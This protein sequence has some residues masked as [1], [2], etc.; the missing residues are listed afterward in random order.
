VCRRLCA[1]GRH[2]LWL[3]PGLPSR[4]RRLPRGRA[5]TRG[6]HPQR[7]CFDRTPSCGTLT[8]MRANGSRNPT[9]LWHPHEK[10]PALLVWRCIRATFGRQNILG[11][12]G[13]RPSRTAISRPPCHLAQL[14]ALPRKFF[15]GNHSPLCQ[16]GEIPLVWLAVLQP[17]ETAISKRAEATPSITRVYLSCTPAGLAGVCT[18]VQ[19]HAGPPASKHS[20]SIRVRYH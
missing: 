3:A 18:C 9:I 17:Q 19:C 14:E 11:R 20:G 7:D 5:H 15:L 6:Q 4:P 2:L 16:H 8:S 10:T 13:W 12:T 1:K